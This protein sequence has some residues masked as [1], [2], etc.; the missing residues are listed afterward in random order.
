MPTSRWSHVKSFF[1]LNTPKEHIDRQ[2]RKAYTTID[3]MFRRC[4][5][6]VAPPFF[7]SQRRGFMTTSVTCNAVPFMGG[8]HSA[9]A[10]TND[11]L[12]E[13]AHC[14]TTSGAGTETPQMAVTTLIRSLSP[15]SLSTIFRH[16]KGFDGFIDDFGRRAAIEL[17]R[18]TESG[19]V[20]VILKDPASLVVELGPLA[21]E[22]A[23][24]RV[25]PYFSKDAGAP[26]SG[27]T[28]KHHTRLPPPAA[29]PAAAAAA[30]SG[31]SSSE[32]GPLHEQQAD[33]RD[34][35]VVKNHIRF[36]LEQKNNS[37]QTVLEVY[38]SLY[39][40]K[41]AQGATSYVEFLNFVTSLA[42]SEYWL[43]KSHIR[44]RKP[45]ETAA[46]PLPHSANVFRV[47]SAH[48]G[49]NFGGWGSLSNV[50]TPADVFEILKYVPV[51]WGN[52]G[53]LQIPSEVKRKHVRISSF[54]QWLRRQPSY[55][56]LR[57]TAGTIEVRRSVVL[58]P[59]AHGFASKDAAMQWLE[60]R[61]VSGEHNNP[62][63]PALS[64][65]PDQ[66]PGTEVMNSAAAQALR[67]FVQRVC[68]G[69]YVP[70]ELMHQRYT[71]KGMSPAEIH[72]VCTQSPELYEVVTLASTGDR[73]YRK[74]VG[75][76]QQSVSFAEAV[77]EL[78]CGGIAANTRALV[79]LMK[80]SCASWDRPEYLYV[81]L[82]EEEKSF[83]GGYEAMVELMRS[84]PH[85]FV[86]GQHYYKRHDATNPLSSS[87]SEPALEDHSVT[88]TVVE[89]NPYLTPRE[90]AVVLHYV[91]P[92]NQAVQVSF[93]VECCSPAM[94]CVL[95]PRVMSLIELFPDLF[96]WREV[97]SGVFT[98][99]RAGSTRRSI[100]ASPSSPSSS[101]TTSGG[102]LLEDDLIPAEE[103]VESVASLLPVM[104]ENPSD[105][106]ELSLL[107]S[108]LSRSMMI[109]AESHFGS[110]E[111]MLR[112]HPARF[113]IVPQKGGT[114]LVARK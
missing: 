70:V 102:G 28:S 78:E 47:T 103:L 49:N 52:M 27:V 86:V 113:H 75:G 50:P 4:R 81:R 31:S 58:H 63:P 64:Q 67:K 54:L 18:S 111:K 72:S 15:T 24:H 92:P 62:N 114:W 88:T 40:S 96:A 44:L 110:I 32:R 12:A 43:V 97:S 112:A 95:P 16:G 101:S 7:A 1:G 45:D 82:S 9:T 91:C 26:P 98:V 42:D 48:S 73:L 17:Q 10:T 66:P 69:Y 56:E 85:V 99:Q 55:F 109:S 84:K 59:E 39:P 94:R 3:F 38:A 71:K 14:C 76:R 20:M 89:E 90:M 29:A 79:T 77:K 5:A 2:S 107:K 25:A 30:P 93:F 61:I 106:V 21:M 36:V 87:A 8:G 19:R 83:V 35:E 53:N 100:G 11:V 60:S 23:S 46:P 51:H 34:A 80:H 41:E 22:A 105:S 68:P 65:Q 74:R 57:N 33:G 6:A 104:S 108:W 13:I 37:Y